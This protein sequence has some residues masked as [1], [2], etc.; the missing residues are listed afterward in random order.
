MVRNPIGDPR[1]LLIF[2]L[3]ISGR[4]FAPNRP[5]ACRVQTAASFLPIGVGYGGHIGLR[6]TR[7]H[8]RHRHRPG[9]QT[10]R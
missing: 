8:H 6:D 4:S 9:A 7:Y 10:Q 5:F 1:E 2:R 3:D